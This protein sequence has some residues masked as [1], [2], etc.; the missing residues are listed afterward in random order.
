MRAPELLFD[1]RVVVA[2]Q[3]VE[4]DVIATRAGKQLHR[5]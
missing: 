5:H 2:V 3:H 1:T 4:G